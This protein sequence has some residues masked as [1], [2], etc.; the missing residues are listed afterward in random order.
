MAVGRRTMEYRSEQTWGDLPV[1]HVS[2]GGRQPNGRYRLGRARGIIALGD[3]A[4][5]LVAVG[6]VAIGLFS[7]GGSQSGLWH[8][9]GWLSGW[10]PSA[11]WPSGWWPSGRWRWG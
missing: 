1:M 9:A 11:G 3:V 2:V 6:G 8:W 10:W 5:G 4:I 7:V